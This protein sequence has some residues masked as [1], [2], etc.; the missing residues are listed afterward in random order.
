MP[1]SMEWIVLVAAIA[2]GVPAL[3]WFAQDRL[4]FF[5][6]PV[7][8]TAHLSAQT[9]P[10]EIVSTDGA[11]LR[12]WVRPAT[13][14]P[15]PVVLYFGGNAEEV[16]WTLADPRWPPDWTVAAVNYRG[17]GASEGRPS[18][19]ALVEDAL[20]IHDAIAARPDV[21]ARRIV[22][23]GRSL[24][25]ALAAKLAAERP[26]AG[27]ILISP[28]DSMVELGRTHYPWLPV[29]W[30]LRH[31]FD[32]SAD[33][34]AARVEMLAIVAAG[35]SIIPPQRSRALHDAWA[36][37]KSLIVVSGANHDSLGNDRAVWDA[38]S[39]FLSARARSSNA[40]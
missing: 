29:S 39:G 20:A 14:V 7:A 36:G 31:R 17:Y 28:Y 9:M 10:L 32:A 21:D 33:A 38:I 3:A 19:P 15:A 16:S 37:P 8:S 12:G 24:G 1:K 18:E 25:T 11:R 6:Q 5:P 22:A 26:V 4:M 2:M 27:A 30:L 40:P 34:R 35:D 13:A 23:V